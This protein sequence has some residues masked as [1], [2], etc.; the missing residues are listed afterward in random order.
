YKDKIRQKRR[1]N[2]AS[3][4]IIR[5]G[6]SKSNVDVSNPLKPTDMQSFF[7]EEVRLGEGLMDA[8]SLEEGAE[9]IAN[10]VINS[11]HGNQLLS[12]VQQAIPPD[13]FALV[14]EK[15]PSNKQRLSPSA[16]ILEQVTHEER[17]PV[18]FTVCPPDEDEDTV[19][20]GLIDPH[21]LLLHDPLPH[22]LAPYLDDDDE[23]CRGYC[24]SPSGLTRSISE[25]G[26]HVA[27]PGL[28]R[29][30]TRCARPYSAISIVRAVFSSHFI[31]R[32]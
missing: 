18:V 26:V 10:A 31:P 21:D 8:G 11:G 23:S 19:F 13:H 29:C 20:D 30:G 7:L 9:H 17:P 24:R 3:R 22:L 15:L 2:A 1:E 14:L 32:L 12:I 6:T 28:A 5:R 27:N 4:S 16:D 25:G